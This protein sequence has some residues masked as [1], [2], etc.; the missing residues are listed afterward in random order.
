MAAFLLM[1]CHDK[2]ATISQMLVRGDMTNVGDTLVA[3]TLE[4]QNNP[5][6]SPT[7]MLLVAPAVLREQ[8]GPVIQI[9]AMP[10]DTLVLTG[11]AMG[12]HNMGGSTFYKQYDEVAKALKGT[13]DPDTLQQHIPTTRPASR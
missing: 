11:D 13:N 9:I 1:A 2:P 4:T 10:G 8:P 6:S 3:L 5:V 7:P 12:D